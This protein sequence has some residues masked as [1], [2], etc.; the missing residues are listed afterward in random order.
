MPTARKEI[1]NDAEEG[2]YHCISRCVRRAYLCGDDPYSGRNFDH[3]KDWVRDRLQ[4]L[5]EYFAVDVFAY[6]LLSNHGHYVLRNRPDLPKTW[7][8]EEVARRWLALF[9]K[10][11]DDQGQALAPTEAETKAI[12]R[13]PKMLKTYRLRLSSI[14]WFMRCLNEFIAR[15]ANK[16]DGCTGRFWEGRFKCT[17]L[18]DEAS[19]LTCMV[20][21]DLNPI[22]AKLSDRPEES[23]FTSAYERIVARQAKAKVKK[24]RDQQKESGK[25]L[26]PAQI[27][28]LS[29]QKELST[30]DRWLS[31]ID[32]RR[33]TGKERLGI[34]AM[35]E[36]EYLELVDLTGRLIRAG[37]RG[38]IPEQLAPMLKR[39]DVDI[40]HWQESVKTFGRMFYRVAGR[41]E[42]LTAHAE[43]I[44]KRWMKGLAGSEALHQTK[45]AG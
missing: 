22:R 45:E 13:K 44:G 43:K 24:L 18:L 4:L 28:A 6:A 10:R 36:D 40:E 1:V 17:G 27:R 5:S 23:E 34:F 39:F 38:V 26:S 42:Q 25:E 9:P 15:A 21:V 3:R 30:K 31:P 35:R 37:K 32:S 8:D 2:V 29:E 41:T 16:E 33:H 7:S 19:I 12:T 14:S 11:R 20:Y